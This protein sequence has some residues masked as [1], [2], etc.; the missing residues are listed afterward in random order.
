MNTKIIIGASLAA[1]F[2][3]FMITPAMATGPET[4]QHVVSSS[5]NSK[6]TQT[7][8]LSVTAADKIPIQTG[9]L[10]GFAWLYADG[11]NTAIVATSHNGVRD[12]AQ[13]PDGWHAHNVQ[14]GTGGLNSDACIEDSLMQMLDYLFTEVHFQ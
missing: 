11:P 12:S 1:V 6:N 14:L 9:V 7:S 2:A 10:G 5:V 4:W 3:V 8:V 13:N